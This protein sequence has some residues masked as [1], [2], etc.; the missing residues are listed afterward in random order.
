M[1]SGAF[2]A[3]DVLQ[4][5]LNEQLSF[6]RISTNDGLGDAL[7]VNISYILIPNN[8]ISLYDRLLN[9]RIGFFCAFSAKSKTP[10]S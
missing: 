8:E 10:S 3:R 1:S 7:H 4:T 2:K 6:T 5:C 9:C